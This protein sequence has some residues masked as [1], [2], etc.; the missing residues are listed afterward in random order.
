MIADAVNSNNAGSSS[1]TTNRLSPTGR[2]NTEAAI[3]R[4]SPIGVVRTGTSPSAA[5]GRS[6]PRA[7]PRRSSQIGI[8]PSKAILT[9]ASRS[10][11]PRS[12]GAGVTVRLS[13]VEGSEVAALREQ[14]VADMISEHL[15]PQEGVVDDIVGPSDSPAG[16]ETFGS[17]SHSLLGGEVTRNIY[18]WKEN[19]DQPRLRR[20]SE[21]DMV[22]PD[23]STSSLQ[24]PTASELREPGM[25]RR[26]FL[27]NK[28][29]Q[30]GKRPPNFITRN[31][32]DFL[33]LYG[34][35]GGDVYPLSDDEDEDDDET[36]YSVRAGSSS[37]LSIAA[38][39]SST[40]EGAESATERTPL[41]GG[42][43][44]THQ[45]SG[46]SPSKAFFMLLKAFV[47]TG[48]LFLPKAF[49]NGGIMFS[50]ILMGV[51]GYLTLHCMILLVETS[52]KL[53]NKS[54]GDIGY[55]LYGEG[56]RQLVLASIA[57]SQMGFCCAYFIFVAQNL[58]DVVMIA[59]DCHWIFPDWVFILVQLL[60]YIPLAWVRRIKNF[61][62]T[63][64]IADVFILLGLG[65]IF[66]FD[67]TII[68]KSG[69]KDVPWINL[70]SFSLFVGTAMFAFEGICLMLPIAESMKEP[71]KFNG[72]LT[73]CIFLIC[74]ILVVI[75]G[76]GYLAL[77]DTVETVI[78]LNLPKSP[79]VTG[80][81]FFYAVA[82]MFSFPLTIYPAIR[83]TEKGIPFARVS[84]DS[85]ILYASIVKMGQ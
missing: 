13:G 4:S 48:V 5:L 33:A 72:V 18:K 57:I 79:F 39:H 14:D 35:Y 53:N 60:L 37:G 75:G 69:F 8:S 26:Y 17:V 40:I 50:T 2:G 30:E 83:I 47:G 24:I 74:I 70:D 3:G 58:R 85:D 31:F 52:R 51:L 78:F 41:V 71:E 61:G 16:Q 56:M 36:F 10:L 25:F 44:Q 34:F 21:P 68:A 45:P 63:S 15:V 55:H 38:G 73:W 19:R 22:L 54:F 23:S 9:S 65:Y 46:T 49:L 12:Y 84:R 29:R 64:L 7:I 32:M 6:L 1:G 11:T 80:L 77:G 42:Q 81:Q 59:S 27:E 20:N 62:I 76:L 67:L 82:I 43:Q 28:A 66:S